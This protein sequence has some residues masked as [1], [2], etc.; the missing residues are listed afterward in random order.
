M[1]GGGRATRLRTILI[2]TTAPEP[3][4][5]L[6]SDGRPA[7]VRQLRPDDRPALESLFASISEEHLYTRFFTLGRGMVA[8]HLDHLLADGPGVTTYVVE[9]R[10][11]LL[12]VCDVERVDASTAEVA[13]LVADDMHGMGIATLLLE[14]AARDAQGRGTGWFVSDVLA[15]NHEMIRVFTDVGFTVELVR[16]GSSVGVRMSTALGQAAFDAVAARRDSAVARAG[17]AGPQPTA[18]PNAR[19]IA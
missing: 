19:P 9:A 11:R 15:R 6:L 8:G 3:E 5:A 4:P 17:S 2:D 18:V 10:D 12:G 7:V 16:R 1:P 13:F 14:R